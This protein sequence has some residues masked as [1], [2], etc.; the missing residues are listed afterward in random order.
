MNLSQLQKHKSFFL[1]LVFFAVN[2]FALNAPEFT[3][4]E[5]KWIEKNPTVTLGA[6][7]NWPPYEF[8]DKS[9]KHTGIA[10]EYLALIAKKS[11]LRFKIKSDVWFNIIE[12]M[13]AGKLDGLG[14]VV[15]TPSRENFLNFTQPYLSMPLV[16]V[17]ENKRNDV[18]K[19]EDL[20]NMN[21]AVNKG[22]YLHEWL[23]K[24]YPQINLT[25]TS[26][27]V[28]SLEL[29][30]TRKVDAYVGNIAVATY[31]MEENF[32]SNLK[33]I[34]KL[35][36]ITTD[37]SIGIS[38]KNPILL[39]I[40]EKTLKTISFEEHNEVVKK[41]FDKSRERTKNK[42]NFT[43]EELEWMKNSSEIT[44]S[45]INW[46]P[47]SIIKDNSM[48]GVM[49]EYLDVISEKTGLKF[50]YIKASSWVEVIEMF[51]K[52]E[53]DMVPGVG[54]SDYESKLGLTSNV[55]ADFPFVL[56]TKINQSFISDISELEGKTIAVPKYWTS[57]NYLREQ[58]PNIKI[59]EVNSVFQALD[60]VEKGKADA[61][62]GHMA[63]GMHYVGTYYSKKLH[64]AGKVDY[65]FNH[66]ILIQ[67]D[68]HILLSIINKVFDSMS[69]ADHRQ[70]KSRWIH[71]K[72]NEAKDYT[73]FYQ[74]GFFLLIVILG[75]VFWNRK[76][77]LE[78]DERKKIQQSLKESEEQMR[79]LIDNI[80]LHVI[81]SSH[82]G[83]AYLANKQTL[84][85]Y[86]TEE[87]SLPLLNVAQFYVDLD[88]RQEVLEELK[89]NGYVDKKIVKLKR[90]SGEYSMMMSI[91]PIKY[92]GENMLLSI[93][94]D[95]TERLKM[96][97]SLFEAKDIAEQASKSKSEF[98]ANMS[99]EIR[100][101]MNAIMGFTELLNEQITQPHLKS[102]VRT[103]RTA[104]GT[105]LSLINDILDLSKIE[106]GKLQ[107]QNV[108]TD[109][110]KLCNEIASIF[111]MNIKSK[112]L[113]FYLDIDKSIP[114]S[115]LLDE[116][117][118]RQILLN[119]IGNSVKFTESGYI[120]LSV[121][122]FNVDEHLSKLDLEIKVEDTGLGI[123]QS[124]LERIFNEFE[125]NEGQDNRK[126]GG[127]GL[128]LSISKRLC[129]MMNGQISVESEEDKGSA[130]IVKLFKIDISSVVNEKNLNKK[131]SE[132]MS[133]IDFHEATILVVDDIEDN[134]A[135]IIHNFQ[136]TKIRVI[137][138]KNGLEAIEIFKK[139]RPDLIL[140]DIR[141]P[142]L[143]GYA[144]ALEIKKISNVPI[145]A[146]TA[147][148]MRDDYE[149]SKR[150][151]FDGFLRKPVLK[152][153]L[154]SEISR[155]LTYDKF[156]KDENI[157]EEKILISEK[158]RLNLSTILQVLSGD[159]KQIQIKAL[160]S[161]NISDIKYMASKIHKLAVEFEVEL[162]DIYASKLYESIDSF[163]I[164]VME[165]LVN[166]F[167][168]LGEKLSKF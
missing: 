126:F 55:Y 18:Q 164:S 115:L 151:N 51:E 119:L 10:A 77:S 104:S 56:V 67:N 41:W 31:T 59:L 40:I 157:K 14:C 27:N 103:I 161:N 13:K 36:S 141:M 88:E 123:P 78:I 135:L 130:F 105:L 42:I 162:L 74:S 153:D 11:G 61:F 129:T 7:Y 57:Y 69:E 86:E 147:S 45:E 47:M 146:L 100:T 4:E 106:A 49:G 6:D 73:I 144:S 109:I 46:E 120:K 98:L 101:P 154:Y 72:V 1:L 90:P 66:K 131:L 48:I 20:K 165:E 96:E 29:V 33:I 82:E 76:L 60:A 25:L 15:K 136:E 93:G 16:V 99:H 35:D 87:K 9:Q 148:V 150:K 140:M 149:H 17:M 28:E 127:T 125:Q 79:T 39:S 50:K 156:E 158:T 63:I 8:L 52:K 168:D 80:P 71:V 167:D 34:T 142:I 110:N 111:T 155:F 91:L 145:I 143:D 89:I 128:G 116:V 44:Y 5:K 117:R 124:Q 159:I 65:S 138:A 139:E 38:K 166:S 30:S 62:M 118:L 134:R 85:D 58:Q 97:K 75:T 102:Y 64:I 133:N 2:L 113:D 95:L 24:N 84:Q 160:S 121:H 94:V 26:S 68:N 114:K 53:I 19:I 70:I 108:P 22:T 112:G 3:L 32:L 132:S 137:S 21:V 83:I 122:A 43:N 163:D 37:V 92:N 107:L 81:V 12:E 152:H 23:V 54:A